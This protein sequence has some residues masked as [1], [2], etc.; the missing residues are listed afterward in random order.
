MKLSFKINGLG[1]RSMIRVF[2][3]D[4]DR[5]G[6]EIGV[7]EIGLDS[8]VYSA[9]VKALTGRHA[10]Y[11]KADTAYDDWTAYM[12]KDKNLFEIEE[13]TFMK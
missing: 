2:A 12:F 11:F 8:G 4:P 10:I 3:G 7:C 6:E 1:C 5:D 9:R 13:F